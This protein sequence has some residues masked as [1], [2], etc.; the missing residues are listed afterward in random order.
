M[1]GA[2]DL[3]R[4]DRGGTVDRVRHRAVHRVYQAADIQAPAMSAYGMPP[5]RLSPTTLARIEPVD[6]RFTAGTASP[7]NTMPIA[8]APAAPIPVHTA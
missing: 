8:G 1:G 5:D 4:P 6:T 7:G 2:D 3:E